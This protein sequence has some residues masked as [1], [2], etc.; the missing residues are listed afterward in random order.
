MR[1]IHEVI[2]EKESELQRIHGELDALR[3]AA[4][5]LE[6]DEGEVRKKSP[7][8]ASTRESLTPTGTGSG[9]QFP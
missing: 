2:Q 6:A 3:L 4:R 9:T 8:P 1:D 5:L 7:A